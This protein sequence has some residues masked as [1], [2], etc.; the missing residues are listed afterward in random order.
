[1]KLIKVVVKCVALPM[2]LVGFLLMLGAFILLGET[3]K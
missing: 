2:L 1:M 3:D